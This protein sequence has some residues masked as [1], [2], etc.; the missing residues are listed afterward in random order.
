MSSL[1]ILAVEDESSIADNVRVALKSEGLTLTH[2]KTAREGL[3]QV[4]TQTFGLVILDVGLP[5]ETGFDLCRKIRKIS[6]VPI[7]FLT[8][9]S[10]E[11]DKIIGFEL[12]ADDYLTKPFSPRELSVRVKA[13]LKRASP[14]SEFVSYG[15]LKI[16][17]EKFK[18]TLGGEPLQLSRYEFKILELL[19]KRP[20][21]V[22][23]R[24]QLME[25]VWE[26]PGMSMDRTVDAHI[27]TIRAKLKEARPDLNLI[28]THRGLGY[29]LK[30]V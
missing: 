17:T 27:K 7:L 2:V 23:S 25:L 13:I 12:G 9:R 19:V 1:N 6:E 10:E 4:Q 11:I 20:G 26:D 24:Q 15:P 16:D 21:V 29:S 8:A 3:A 5:D 22:F 18:I 14:K 28:E 30:E